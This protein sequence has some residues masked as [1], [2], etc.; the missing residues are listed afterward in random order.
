MYRFIFSSEFETF[1]V[2]WND[3]LGTN[4][5]FQ[6]GNLFQIL[7]MFVFNI[8]DCISMDTL[9][10]C[11]SLSQLLNRFLIKRLYTLFL[12][13]KS[14]FVG[15]CYILVALNVC[16]K[17]LFLQELEGSK[18]LTAFRSFDNPKREIIRAP[19]RSKSMLSAFFVKQKATKLKAGYV[20]WISM[21]TSQW[22]HH[23]V[24]LSFMPMELPVIISLVWFFGSWFLHSVVYQLLEMKIS[25][26]F[27]F[28]PRFS[29]L[30][31]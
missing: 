8:G 27:S 20:A 10:A 7:T 4:F 3:S 2:Y 1:T 14:V 18:P 9:S 24:N 31:F 30:G 26:S 6:V 23:Y 29:Y 21:R 22:R 11:L 12:V 17:V 16:G 19:V 25:F 13:Q 15:Y 28:F 5:W